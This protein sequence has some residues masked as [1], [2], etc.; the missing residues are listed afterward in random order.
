MWRLLFSF[1]QVHTV[2]LGWFGSICDNKLK[3]FVSHT[4]F[5]LSSHLIP[6]SSDVQHIYC[7][8]FVVV[9][10]M[11][12]DNSIMKVSITMP[13]ID[14]L[15]ISALFVSALQI[16]RIHLKWSTASKE[17]RVVICDETNQIFKI[18]EIPRAS[19]N[20]FNRYCHFVFHIFICVFFCHLKC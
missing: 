2:C 19:I 11:N 9:L 14:R 17:F 7:S 8:F 13:R 3:T 4:P 5:S 6:V 16:V 10:L 18:C 1:I 20:R 12:S 15:N